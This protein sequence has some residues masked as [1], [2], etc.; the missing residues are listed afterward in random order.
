M[1]AEMS[2]DDGEEGEPRRP[3]VT[4]LGKPTSVT[5]GGGE[6]RRTSAPRIEAPSSQ[7]NGRQ[8]DIKSTS[9]SL[10]HNGNSLEKYCWSQDKEEVQL[11]IWIE[12]GIGAKRVGVVV[13]KDNKR[14]DIKV[15]NKIYLSGEL[16]YDVE[17]DE[18]YDGGIEW[19]LDSVES[20]RRI[21]ITLKKKCPIQGATLWWSRCFKREEKLDTSKIKDRRKG[22]KGMREAWEEAHKLFR[23]KVAKQRP[24]YIDDDGNIVDVDAKS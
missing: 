4:Y 10:S 22:S 18:D 16:T 14:L 7:E 6:S 3:N 23:A 24:T 12:T 5:I 2:D 13:D 19:Q 9:I 1:V 20:K 15:D 21:A 8:G 17:V 11:S